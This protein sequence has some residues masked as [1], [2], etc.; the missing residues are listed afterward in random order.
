MESFESNETSTIEVD[1]VRFETVVSQTVLTIPEAKRG[2]RTPLKVGIR[3]TN[4]TQSFFYF[5]SYAYSMLPEIMTPDGQVMMTGLNTDGINPPFES[6]YVLLV[7]REEIILYCD[8]FVFWRQNRKKKRDKKL[9]FGITLPSKYT[10]VFEPLYPGTYQFRFR[11][12]E[13]YEELTYSCNFIEPAMVQT[14]LQHLWIGEVLTPF[15][16]IQLVSS[17]TSSN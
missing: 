8:A 13:A 11:Y 5:S 4:N 6:D 15:V 1:G 2:V 12:R 16:N 7:P 10:Y 9:A 3:I 14:I 17:A